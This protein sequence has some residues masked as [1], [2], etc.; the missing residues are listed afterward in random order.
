MVFARGFAFEHR[1]DEN[2]LA[3][4]GKGLA[5]GFKCAGVD[6][7]GADLLFLGQFAQ[8]LQARMAQGGQRGLGLIARHGQFRRQGVGENLWPRL[9]LFDRNLLQD[10]RG[11]AGIA[12]AISQV[13]G[14]QAQQG[15][16]FR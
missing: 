9:E 10:L 3:S 1:G 5:I 12:L 7:A 6:G 15:G 2:A 14:A 11:L 8:V 16:I 13:G 4:G